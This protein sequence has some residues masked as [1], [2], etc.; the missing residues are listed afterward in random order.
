MGYDLIGKNRG[1][2]SANIWSWGGIVYVCECAG[3]QFPAKWFYYGGDGP[4][5]QEECD[6]IADLLDRYLKR[7]PDIKEFIDKSIPS[8]EFVVGVDVGANGEVELGFRKEYP[9]SI[10]RSQVEEFINFLR[11]CGGFCIW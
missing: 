8:E 2:Y 6:A 4:G 9:V 11:I 1:D 7:N 5:S 3:F 10:E